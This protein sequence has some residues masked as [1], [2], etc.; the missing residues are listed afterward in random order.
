MAGLSEKPAD[1]G[2]EING[3]QQRRH[4]VTQA[5]NLYAGDVDGDG[6]RLADP[7][8]SEAGRNANPPRIFCSADGDIPC[9][10]V[11]I[12]LG[13][14]IQGLKPRFLLLSLH[15]PC[16]GC[17]IKAP[18]NRFVGVLT[19]PIALLLHARVDGFRWRFQLPIVLANNRHLNCSGLE[20]PGISSNILFSAS[21]NQHNG[22]PMK[23]DPLTPS[24]MPAKRFLAYWYRGAFQTLY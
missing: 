2:A 9:H 12:G 10:S 7:R 23:V 17:P 18:F 14:D 4:N 11:Y 13:F 1:W 5:Q 15:V 19:S 21:T 24:N 6:I 8:H 16:R 20:W 3:L 22:S